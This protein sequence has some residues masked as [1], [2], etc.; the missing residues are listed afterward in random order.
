MKTYK[1]LTFKEIAERVK[2]KLT[3]EE[4][5]DMY[6]TRCLMKLVRLFKWEGLPFPS[7]EL[8]IRAILGG[9]AGVVYD[10]NVGMMTAWGGM[11]VPTQYE[12]YFKKF[13]YAAP[14]AKGGSKV[15]GKEA[16]ILRNTPLA[17]SASTWLLR[18]AQLYAHT[19]ISLTMALVNSRYQDIL[20]T[21]DSTKSETLKEWY[22]GLY[23]GAM[24]ALIDDSPLSELGETNGAIS[25]LDLT[26]SG[27]V[28]FTRY[29]ELENELTRSFYR[30]IGIRWNKDKKANLVSGEVEQDNMLLEFNITDMLTSREEFCEEYKKVFGSNISVSLTIPIEEGDY[31]E[32]DNDAVSIDGDN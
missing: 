12:D 21:T 1:P 3:L 32:N 10:K 18:Y 19:D 31:S 13:S 28:D 17:Y 25:A 5:I 4:L 23:D 27:E 2:K 20:K 16:V 6:F 8:E 9:Y 15:I 30:E 29:T 7:H 26:K 14:T 22:K 24:L 11:S